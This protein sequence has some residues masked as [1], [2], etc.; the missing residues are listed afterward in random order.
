MSNEA[1]SD[2]G[3]IGFPAFLSRAI[4]PLAGVAPT[5]MTRFGGRR[6][7]SKRVHDGIGCGDTQGACHD[8]YRGELLPAGLLRGQ[9]DYFGA[10]TCECV[11]DSWG[12]F[13][14][15]DWPQGDLPYLEV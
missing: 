4:L 11:H 6:G 15:V 12:R 9:R 5:G 10:H 7:S 14:H 3:L 13:F 1:L 2:M 8:G